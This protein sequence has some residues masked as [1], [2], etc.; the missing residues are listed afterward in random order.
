MPVIAS[1]EKAQNFSGCSFELA[2]QVVHLWPVCIAPSYQMAEQFE[3][4]LAPEERDRAAKF[5]FDHLRRFFIVARGALRVLLRCYLNAH[6]ASIRFRYGA[7]G[8]P[9]IEDLSNIRFNISHSGNLAVFVFTIGWE[10]GVDVERVRPR[11][12]MYEIVKH[13]FCLEEAADLLSVPLYQR[14]HAFF[15]CWTRKEAYIKAVGDGLFISLDYFQVTLQPDRPTA[16]VHL[17]YNRNAAK[18]W[19]LHDLRLASR[20][21]SALA[22]RGTPR[23]IYISP[24]VEPPEL[25]KIR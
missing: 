11:P 22:Y 2:E 10:I 9:H 17:G 5:G 12:D 13:F 6:P 18:E 19:V 4:I 15:L 25:L 3:L 20:Y 1:N 23:R 14:T 21:A 24:I 7:K 8:K 16:I